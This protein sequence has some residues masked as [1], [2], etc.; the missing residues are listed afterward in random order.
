LVNWGFPVYQGDG[1]VDGESEG[2]HPIA[3]GPVSGREHGRQDCD[4]GFGV[5]GDW[6]QPGLRAAGLRNALSPKVV[7]ARPPRKPKYDATVVAALEKCCGNAECAGGQ[8]ARADA[9]RAGGVLRRFGE[10]DID[11]DTF[12][13]LAGMSA[14]TIDRRLAPAKSMPSAF[15][16]TIRDGDRVVGRLDDTV[17][18]QWLYAAM[19]N[20]G[21]HTWMFGRELRRRSGRPLRADTRKAGLRA[22]RVGIGYRVCHRGSATGRRYPKD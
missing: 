11:D 5:S 7:A 22:R 6:V 1:V 17:D 4:P 12:K 16:W 8:A 20:I 19:G 14:A 15:R 9:G 21:L 2:D 13:L 18:S 10:L 3:G